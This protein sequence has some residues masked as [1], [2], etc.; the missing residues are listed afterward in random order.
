MIK[1]AGDLLTRFV[2]GE[3]GRSAYEQ[4]KGKAST[5]AL[6]KFGEK[7]L[8]P[9]SFTEDKVPDWK[10]LHHMA[11]NLA[12]GIYD[13]SRGDYYTIGDQERMFTYL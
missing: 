8:Y 7:I 9:W 3:S 10:E 13:T 5:R 12:S 2:V 4:I 6:A 1:W 11:N